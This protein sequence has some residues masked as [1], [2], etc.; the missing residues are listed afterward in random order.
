MLFY[1]DA[2]LFIGMFVLL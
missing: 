1:Q 2:V